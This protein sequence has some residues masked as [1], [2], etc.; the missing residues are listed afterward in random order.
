M[1]VKF[2][3][4]AMLGNQVYVKGDEAEFPEITAGE[5][6]KKKIANEVL[7]REAKAESE[8]KATTAKPKTETQSK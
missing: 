4:T 1:K 7:P 3:D 5:L 2:L 8:R 6:V